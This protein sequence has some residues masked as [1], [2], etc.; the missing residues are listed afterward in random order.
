[1]VASDRSFIFILLSL[2]YVCKYVGA[3]RKRITEQN[4][5]RNARTIAERLLMIL[6][7]SLGFQFRFVLP[8]NDDGLTYRR[9]RAIVVSFA[10]L[11]PIS[12]RDRRLH[13]A[14]VLRLE[15]SPSL[16]SFVL[17]NCR[18]RMRENR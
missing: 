9:E 17:C 7:I 12:Q 4:G 18:V 2:V 15:C 14:Q 6:V 8:S 11:S 3:K 10:Q 13:S 1:M 16:R 5:S